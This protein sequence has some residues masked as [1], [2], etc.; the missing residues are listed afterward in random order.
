MK[1][2]INSSAIKG[3]SKHFFAH[4]GILSFLLVMVILIY[5]VFSIQQIM[6]SPSD[7]GYR[8]EQQR[9]NTRTTFDRQ[10]IGKVERL[11][12]AEE[13]AAIELP[14]GRINPFAE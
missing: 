4:Y 13:S 11:R 12:S 10:T 2:F 14:T 1:Q 3:L 6:S 5:S 9:K 8:D 7:S